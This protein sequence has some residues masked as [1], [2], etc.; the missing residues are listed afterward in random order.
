MG[1][2]DGMQIE[3]HDYAT[4]EVWH[5][6]DSCYVLGFQIFANAEKAVS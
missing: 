6:E 5:T 1:V 4:N 2:Y 3:R